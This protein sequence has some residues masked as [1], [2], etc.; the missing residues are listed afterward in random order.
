MSLHK[1]IK[2]KK[3]SF[4]IAISYASYLLSVHNVI[5]C[6]QQAYG[7]IHICT[8][9]PI[10]WMWRTLK[11]GKDLDWTTSCQDS[12]TSHLTV[13]INTKENKTNRKKKKRINNK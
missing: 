4:F 9:F 10:K 5:A 7:Y 2:E 13:F 1:Q 3:K 11:D 8:Q 12:V 6:H